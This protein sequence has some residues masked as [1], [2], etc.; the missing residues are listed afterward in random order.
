[1]RPPDTA[2]LEELASRLARV[3]PASARGLHRELEDNFRA[4][5]RANLER[6][7]L[8]ARDRFDAQAELLRRTQVRLKALEA[9]LAALETGA[10]P[11]D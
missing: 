11:Q 7:D 3:V 9:R 5:L 6:L 2:L 4:V 8:V 10:A 1:M